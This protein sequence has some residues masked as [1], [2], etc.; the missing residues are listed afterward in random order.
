MKS[1]DNL[2]NSL[3]LTI[4]DNG[5][6]NIFNDVSEIIIDKALDE[7]LLRDIPIVNTIRSVIKAGYSISDYLFTKKVIEF[8]QPLSKYTVDERKEFL[9]KLDPEQLNKATESLIFYLNRL[10][11][12][13]KAEMLGKI[14]EAYMTGRI[15]QKVMM[16]LSYYVDAVFI[17]VW[18]DFYK[19]IL[20]CENSSFLRPQINSDD[21]L[22]LE[23]VGFYEESITTKLDDRIQ[24]R[25]SISTHK[26]LKLSDGG[27]EFIQIVWGIG[28]RENDKFRRRR[29]DVEID[30]PSN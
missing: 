28:N 29:F 4:K 25:T 9:N 27:W 5:M 26:N 8:L 23:K 22:A 6:D 12:I 16:Y 15:D 2:Q 18:E 10:D 11:S 20:N 17:I 14:F 7:G 1:Q 30:Y 21:A 24:Q 13:K 19:S 3:L